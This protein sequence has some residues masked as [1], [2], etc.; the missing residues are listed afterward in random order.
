MTD[1]TC[2]VDGCGRPVYGHGLCSKH[3][4]RKRRTGTTDDPPDVCKR[5]LHHFTPENTYVEPSGKRVCR[6]CRHVQVAQRERPPCSIEGCGKSAEK[7]GWCAMHYHRWRLTGDPGAAEPRRHAPG[8]LRCAVGGCESS[9]YYAKGLCSLHYQR[10]WRIGATELTVVERPEACTVD[11]CDLTV[12]AQGLCRKHYLRVW[13]TGSADD[14]VPITHCAKGHE[15]TD[16]NTCIYAGKRYCRTCQLARSASRRAWMSDPEP[17]DYGLILDQY[18]MACH[19]CSREIASRTD[20]HFDHVIP[21]ARGGTHTYDN[22]R[23][24]HKTCNLIKGTKLMS[25]L[26]GIAS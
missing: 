9:D 12:L 8:T 20:L 17:L 25:E 7:R 24:A 6:A 1:R 4:Q 14:P 10:V 19:I 16:E 13:R 18:G 2:S 3:Y 21:R 11:G 26:G 22:V 15:F 5:G 23:P